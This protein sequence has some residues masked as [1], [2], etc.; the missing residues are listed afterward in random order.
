MP[1]EDEWDMSPEVGTLG[2]EFRTAESLEDCLDQCLA[3]PDC[4]AVDA[5][6][7]L[8]FFCFLHTN[9]SLTDNEDY[10]NTFISQYVLR[11]R[12]DKGT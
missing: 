4:V 7:E 9:Q 3:R 5:R 10:T 12:C 2:G 1:C 6:T 11:T 8:P